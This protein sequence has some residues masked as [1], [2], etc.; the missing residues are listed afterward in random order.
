[1]H[2]HP[3]HAFCLPCRG[4]ALQFLLTA[5]A[6][7][8]SNQVA[9]AP[10][11]VPPLAP[12]S[13]A[14]QQPPAAL[15]SLL[16]HLS[17]PAPTAHPQQSESATIVSS[18]LPLHQRFLQQVQ[19]KHDALRRLIKICADIALGS[20]RLL[21]ASNQGPQTSADTNPTQ[22]GEVGQ[23][24]LLGQLLTVLDDFAHMAKFSLEDTVQDSLLYLSAV[25]EAAGKAQRWASMQLSPCLHKHKS[26][27]SH[28]SS[29]DCTY[30]ALWSCAHSTCTHC[31][32]LKTSSYYLSCA[33]SNLA[34][35]HI[36]WYHHDAWY[37]L[38]KGSF[39]LHAGH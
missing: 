12:P 11:P 27:S 35:H 32:Y 17:Q 1:M 22:A 6:P 7:S 8:G 34:H 2:A 36:P 4:A 3:L 5:V 33:M 9:K 18:N 10:D 38:N 31:T 29:D 39:C 13:V 28:F 20:S 26:P 21:P 37:T 19:S 25:A 24:V 16:A 30:A 23:W 15:H 14:P